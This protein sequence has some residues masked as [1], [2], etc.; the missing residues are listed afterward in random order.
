[1]ESKEKESARQELY[2][3][4]EEAEGQIRQGVELLDGEE[5]F[6]SLKEKYG[7]K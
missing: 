6:N 5:V 2:K 3:K 1:M 4:I 7:L